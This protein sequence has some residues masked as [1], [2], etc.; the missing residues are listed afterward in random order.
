MTS[1]G[2]E[3]TTAQEAR[4]SAAAPKA[5]DAKHLALGELVRAFDPE[6]SDRDHARY[7]QVVSVDLSAEQEQRIVNPDESHPTQREVL[8]LHWHPEFIPIP[9]IHRRVDALFPNR[10]AELLIPTQH[11]VLESYDGQFTGVE[12]DC[13]SP[14]FNRKVQL[15]M[16]VESARLDSPRAAIFK[17]MLAHTFKY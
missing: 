6:L 12:V 11:N 5:N 9:L 1:D 14:E 16:H 13:Y 3:A 15:L 10:E 17:N 7:D 8:A 2:Y 4:S